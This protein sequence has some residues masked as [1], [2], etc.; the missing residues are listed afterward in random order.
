MF[1]NVVILITPTRVCYANTMANHE[2]MFIA[3]P[4]AVA[5]MGSWD[6]WGEVG[7]AKKQ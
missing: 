2:T 5:L 6:G 7:L 3:W 1:S 4:A